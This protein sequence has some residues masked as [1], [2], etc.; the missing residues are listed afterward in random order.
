MKV[1]HSVDFRRKLR[2]LCSVLHLNT[3]HRDCCETLL[4][5]QLLEC[6]QSLR[7]ETSNAGLSSINICGLALRNVMSHCGESQNGRPSENDL[8]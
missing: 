8:V 2:L 3:E 5:L 6:L 4:M 1:I 7:A